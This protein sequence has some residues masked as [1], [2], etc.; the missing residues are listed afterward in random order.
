[1]Q[2]ISAFR[3]L[4]F[5]FCH[6]LFTYHWDFIFLL[7]T[8]IRAFIFHYVSV[9]FGCSFI[10]ETLFLSRIQRPSRMS[11]QIE[12]I[13]S[14][15]FAHSIFSCYTYKSSIFVL[16]DC[17]CCCCCFKLCCS[18][19]CVFVILSF[20]VLIVIGKNASANMIQ[21]EQKS[22]YANK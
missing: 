6:A 22:M 19:G 7:R 2:F 9:C 16:Y 20:D 14:S 15:H 4:F 1:M 12:E 21:H 3:H 18:H 10:F 8:K 5:A 13:L 11:C 17:C